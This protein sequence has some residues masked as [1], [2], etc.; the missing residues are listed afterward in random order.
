[1][2]AKQIQQIPIYKLLSRS[3]KKRSLFKYNN[4]KTQRSS[5]LNPATITGKVVSTFLGRSKMLIKR[6]SFYL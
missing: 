5:S 4:T 3:F 2:N 6:A 1:M